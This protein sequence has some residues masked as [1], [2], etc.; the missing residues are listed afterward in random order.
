MVRIDHDFIG[1]VALEAMPWGPHRVK[2]TPVRDK[3][4][5]LRLFRELMGP[6]PGPKLMEMPAGPHEAHLH[7][8]LLKD[9]QMEGLS[10]YP[11]YSA[12][13]RAWISLAMVRADLAAQG[14]ALQI[15][16]GERDDGTARPN[17]ER[18]VQMQVG[19]EVHPWPIHAAARKAYRKQV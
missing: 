3:A 2:V 14:T 12:N 6:F 11:V 19:A 18:H 9:G 17:V 1:Q 15:L 7:D 4:D 10:N 16:W 8:Q 5:V 13:E